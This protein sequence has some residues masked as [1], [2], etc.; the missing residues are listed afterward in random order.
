[1]LRLSLFLLLCIGIVPAP[2]QTSASKY[3]PGTILQVE[4]HHVGAS[5]TDTEPTQYDVSVR[6]DETVYVVL[7]TPSYG[8]NTVEFSE[9]L[10]FLF[11]VGKETLTL[12][13][14]G[15]S[16]GNT[17]LPILRTTKLPAQ[18][19]IDWSKAPSQYYSMKMKNLSTE[20]NLSD[21]QQAKIKPIAEQESAEAGGVIFTQVVPRKE[22]L[23][24]WEKIVR[25]S[26][27]KMKP[28]LS[29]AQWQK[30]QE[31][32]KDQKRELKDLIAK[33]D[34]EGRK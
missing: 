15:K 8:S 23:S 16:D 2:C 29:Q 18:P 31:L 30:L 6:I 4:R 22:R 10:E 9:G 1:M 32:R 17:N 13:T 27:Q 28:V 25:L 3:Q 33:K 5:N 26:D 11:S 12:A 19:A 20:L 7:Y 14:P 34:S 21:E 24:Q